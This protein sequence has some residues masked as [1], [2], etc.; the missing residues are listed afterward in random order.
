MDVRLFGYNNPTG[1]CQACAINDDGLHRC[2]DSQSTFSICNG[3]RLCDSFFI[4]CL[5]PLNTSSI[6]EEGC[7]GFESMTSNVNR[8]DGP[9]DFE[10][11][12]V[13]GLPNP[14]L[15]PGLTE[16]YMVSEYLCQD[17]VDFLQT[18]Q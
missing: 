11:P 13:L 3:N 14:L 7:S 18:T 10:N 17:G 8:N 15:L 6:A 2:C 12:T 1:R 9:V 4:Y 5:R 16:I